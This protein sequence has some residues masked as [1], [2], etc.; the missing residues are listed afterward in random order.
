MYGGLAGRCACLRYS[1]AARR[2]CRAL[3]TV[4]T[5]DATHRQKLGNNGLIR[6]DGKFLRFLQVAEGGES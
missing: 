1:T 6:H 4:C 2:P 5:V 3:C